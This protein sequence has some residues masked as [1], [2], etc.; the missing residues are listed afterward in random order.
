[1]AHQSL[2]ALHG[3]LSAMRYSSSVRKPSGSLPGAPSKTSSEALKTNAPML[4]KRQASVASS[5]ALRAWK[6]AG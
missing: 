2:G 1:L 6:C 3:S 5:T 4:L